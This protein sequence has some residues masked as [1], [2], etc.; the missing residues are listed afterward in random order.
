M[1]KGTIFII[2][3]IIAL[4]LLFL[5]NN[6]SQAPENETVNINNAG[7]ETQNTT[8]DTGAGE[9]NTADN[10][11]TKVREFAVVGSNFK[12]N[13]SNLSVNKGDTVKIT[14]KNA[15]GFHDLKIDELGVATKQ[16][17]G[18]NE[19]T[20]TFVAD[21]VGSFVYYCSVGTHRQNGMW[22]TLTVN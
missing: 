1:K 20:I 3:I 22:G 7:T 5:L 6:K 10:L 12:F 2:V 14:F 19:E 17:S 21:K 13:P 9:F 8:K 16:I 15:E 4:G 18:G 11:E